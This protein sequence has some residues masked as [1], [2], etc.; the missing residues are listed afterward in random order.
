MP[1]ATKYI[2]DAN[3]FIQASR[4]YYAFDFAQHF[5]NNLVVY[6]SQSKILSLD[7]VLA[8]INQ[9]DDQLKKWA[10]RD[11]LPYFENSQT[12]AVV[13]HYSTLV[14]WADE[15]QVY[16]QTAKDEFMEDDNAD[17]WIIS[18]AMAHD[19]TVVTD[20]IPDPASKKRIKIPDVC[21]MFGIPY[22]DLFAMLRSLGFGF[23]T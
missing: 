10:N 18:Y 5:W 8:E 21:N 16:I 6:G 20:E 9:G 22:C 15:H 3:T 23:N 17:A 13:Q 1:T 14:N 4:G 11:F 2:V 19:C 12:S 7:K